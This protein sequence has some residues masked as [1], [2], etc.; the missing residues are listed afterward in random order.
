MKTD[1]KNIKAVAVNLFVFSL[2]FKYRNKA[3]PKTW[4]L[5]E[6]NK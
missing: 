6:E 2:N 3:C 4:E 1:V 5:M